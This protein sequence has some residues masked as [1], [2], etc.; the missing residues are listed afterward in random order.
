M[1][2]MRWWSVAV[3]VLAAA[4]AEAQSFGPTAATAVPVATIWP[5]APPARLY[6]LPFSIDPAVVEQ[7][8]QEASAGLVPK[9]PVRQMMASRPRVVDAVTGYDRTEPPGAGVARLVADEMRQ[10]G[11]PVEL[12]TGPTPPPADGWRLTGQ[13]VQLDEGS[14]AA[15]NAIGFGVGNKHIGIDVALSDPATAGGAPFFILDSSDKR[16]MMPGT[17]AIGAAAGFNPY[18]VAGKLVASNSGLSDIAQQQRLA[19][20]I[21][22][23][24]ADAI[25]QHAVPAR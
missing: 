10:A 5:A 24:V 7:V 21:A 20:K 17:V 1:H 2:A 25:N 3:G 8:R 6:V 19:D 9:G 16:R 4:A 15:R 18:V 22:R 13:V 11:W 14:A 12:W 23:A